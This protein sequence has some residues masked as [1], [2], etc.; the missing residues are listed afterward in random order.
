MFDCAAIAPAWFC[1]HRDVL[2]DVSLYLLPSL[3]LALVIRRLS[4]VHPVFF[5]FTLAGT[6]CHELAHFCIGLLTGARPAG[7]SVVPRRVGRN[8][9]LGSVSLTRVRWYNAAPVALAP[10]LVL[11]V[12][13]AVALWRTH[14][15][16]QFQPLDLLLAFA[17]APQ[18]LAC[19]PSSVDWKISLRSWPYVVIGAVAWSGSRFVT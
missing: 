14:P 11:A 2:L 8:W 17:V 10:F 7:F 4:S 6:I 13:V 9:Q 12:P 1:Q 16:W 5:L 19:W 3:A 18:F 15:G